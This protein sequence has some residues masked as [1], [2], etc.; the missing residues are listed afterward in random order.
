[1]QDTHHTQDQA[2]RKIF[3]GPKVRRLRLDKGLSQS[4]MAASLGFSVSYLNL[5]E[6]NQRPLSAQFL[7][8]LA[9]IYTVDLASFAGSEQARSLGE[10]EE[11]LADPLFQSVGMDR[12]EKQDL[13]DLS[14]KAVT[15]LTLL[16]RAYKNSHQSAADLSARM[17]EQAGDAAPLAAPV[18]EV[19]DFLQDN[20][21]YFGEIDEIGEALV[22]EFSGGGFGVGAG[23][24]GLSA[25]D[26]ESILLAELE[27]RHGVHVR[28]LPQDIMPDTLRYFDYHRRQLQIS[29]MLDVNQRRF[30]LA[31]QLMHLEC[32]DL[33]RARVAD[34]AH[35]SSEEARRLARL[36]LTN[37]AA[38]ALLMP[39]GA[40]LEAA[41]NLGYDL[42]HLSHRFSA[43]FE[44]VCHRLTT[45]NRPGEK[46]IP[47]FF[48]RVD[49]AGNISKRFAAG[50][51]PFSRY[52]GTC[53]LWALHDSFAQPGRTL[54]QWIDLPDGGRYFTLSRCLV[55]RPASA[56][57]R[58]AEYAVALGCEEK[59]A[60]GLVYLEA[61]KALTSEG[62]MPVGPGCRLCERTGCVQRAHPPLT[63]T[64][65][66]DSL[67]KGMGGYRFSATPA[68]GS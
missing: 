59:H 37:Y 10:L 39:Y 46:G 2:P 62:A 25:L 18:E 43:T 34:D 31:F 8:K 58:V 1:M 48:V 44:Q 5:V 61:N 15:A 21:N 32:R 60:S 45:L 40:F 9:E 51:F 57:S 26:G 13:A 42:D 68:K 4:E 29:E 49:K 63:Q 41:R 19:R 14:P 6:R 65:V 20:H 17:A 54:P 33:I 66:V 22:R 16:Y 64:L 28:I 24:Y 27:A 11:I 7:L 67:N 56:S 55:R 38:A 3:A 35:F 23:G 47:F 53:P 30:H 12:G 36:S 52:G 50:R